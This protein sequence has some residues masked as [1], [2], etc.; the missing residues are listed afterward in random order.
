M[1]SKFSLLFAVLFLSCDEVQVDALLSQFSD[2]NIPITT[3]TTTNTTFNS[4]T[5][6][7]S[8]S[9]NE[10]ATSFSYQLEPL[11][12]TDM[13]MTH[14]NWSGW[15]TLDAV[16]FTNLDAGSYN[17]HIKSRFT[18]ENEEAVQSIQFIVDAIAG[19]ALR[20]YPLYQQ[21]LTGE[22]FNIYIY[23]EDVAELGGMEMHLSYPSSK[24][25]YIY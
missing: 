9:G 3:I 6:N 8:W 11:S 17:F 10:Y 22:N 20:I 5:V 25:H 14:T 4:S 21:V 1:K 16:T 2:E 7:V 12:Y 23:I 13:V 24:S 19:P 15:D 18:V